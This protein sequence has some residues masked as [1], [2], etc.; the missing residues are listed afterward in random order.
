MNIFKAWKFWRVFKRAERIV[1]M[2]LADK[3]PG[4]HSLTVWGAIIGALVPISHQLLQLIPGGAAYAEPIAGI[5]GGIAGLLL[6]LGGR[7]VLGKI[8]ANKG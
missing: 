8:A 7:R 4:E 6:L 3:K 2:E 1:K 5:L